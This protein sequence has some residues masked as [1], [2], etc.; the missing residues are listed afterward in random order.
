VEKE[1]DSK[2]KNISEGSV[3]GLACFD[4]ASLVKLLEY[5]THDPKF[6][7]SNPALADTWRKS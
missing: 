3:G 6:E 5:S 1:K 2:L 7:G 4:E